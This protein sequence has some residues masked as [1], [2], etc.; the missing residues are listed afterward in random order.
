MLDS[1]SS[2][3]SVLEVSFSSKCKR[4]LLYDLSDITLYILFDAWWTS[5]NVG[6]QPPISWNNSKYTPTWWFYLPYRIGDT[7]STGIICI[8]RNQVLW[9]RSEHGTRSI[10]KQLQ[11]KVCPTKWN[12]LTELYFTK[13]TTSTVHEI[14]LIIIKRCGSRGYPIGCSHR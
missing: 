9:H 5:M 6:W 3:T 2:H 11:A 7:C 13:L 12:E 14:A 10:G 4:V 8:I 1:K